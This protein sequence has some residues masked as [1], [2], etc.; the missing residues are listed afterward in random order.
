MK[1]FRI[2]IIQ[3]VFMCVAFFSAAQVKS[4]PS[5]RYPLKT[6]TLKDGL[7]NNSTNNIITDPLGFTWVST[8]TGLQRYNGYNLVTITPVAGKDTFR[9]NYPVYFFKLENGMIW[10]SIKEGVLEYDSRSNSFRQVI[11]NRPE[12]NTQF[13]IVPLKET[14]AGIWC[15]QEGEG[16]V[17]YNKQGKLVKQFSFVNATLANKIINSQRYLLTNTTAFTPNNIVVYDKY[18]FIINSVGKILSINTDSEKISVL[19]GMDKNILSIACNGDNIFILSDQRLFSMN[20]IT[21]VTGKSIPVSDILSENVLT[22]CLLF[23]ENNQLLVSINGHLYEFDTGKNLHVEISDPQKN[24]VL[25]TGYILKIY[26]DKFRRIWLLTNNDVKRIQN[27]EMPFEQYKYP[28]E[29]N[30]FVRTIYYDDDKKLLLAGCFNGG[31]QLYDTSA[32]A[33]WERSLITAKIIDI[34]GIEKLA[35]DKYLLITLGRGWYILELSSKRLSPLPIPPHIDTAFRP[36]QVNFSNNLRRINDSIIIIAT[37][38]NIFWCHFAGDRLIHA[39]PVLPTGTNN[40][41]DCFLYTSD[42]T[43]WVGTLTGML[44]RLTR[45]KQL[46]SIPV[47]GNYLVRSLAEDFKHNIWVGADKGLYVFNS[48]GVLLKKF[49]REDGLL[50]DCIYSILPVNE[51]TSVYAGSNLGLSFISL[52]GII[53]NFTK[54]TGLQDDEFNT[55]AAIKTNTGKYFFG[56]IN[57]ISAFYPG[58]LSVIHDTPTIHLARLV[59]NDSLFNSSAGTWMGDTIRLKHNQNHLRIDLVSLGLLDATEYIYHY[60]LLGFENTWQTTLHPLGIN[61]T[62]EP[63]SYTFEVRCSPVLSTEI[64]FT[65]KFLIIIYPPWWKTWWFR[66][67]AILSMV[68]IIAITVQQYNS[69]KYQKK[70]QALQLEQE[71]QHERERISR[72]LH[73]DMGT[74]ANMLMYDASRLD[75]VNTSEELHLIKKRLQDTTGDMLQSLRETVWTLKQEHINTA[76]VWTRAKNFITKLQNT[77]KQILFR[78]EEKESPEIQLK[79]NKA[80]NLIR[81]MQEAVNNAVKHSGCTEIICSKSPQE[82]SMLFT[83]TDNGKGFDYPAIIHASEGNGLQNMRQRAAE[84]GLIFD[85]ESQAGKGTRVSIQV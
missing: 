81:I 15:M 35:N 58:S 9:I 12:T 23:T 43:L 82:N 26:C 77:Y 83:I 62:L 19:D 56:G 42:E 21:G 4:H 78:I 8:I 85:L 46:L 70:I 39:Q 30:N 22:G 55:G 36:T 73:D 74:S 64:F 47:P 63:G 66:I 28:N 14:P 79:Y 13:N 24:P 18:I 44:Y 72:E 52:D 60:R 40:T 61:F 41:I 54:E 71:L 5:K 20:F 11:F 69:R 48:K 84:S 34:I 33:L 7:L 16:V 3:G 65:K 27:V 10:I 49:T 17:I 45:D 68:S 75:E 29:K 59:V 25:Q 76:D 2:L 67:A 31:V 1:H 51:E 80:F 57:G 53:K 6:I 32:N 38:A 50:N 37:A